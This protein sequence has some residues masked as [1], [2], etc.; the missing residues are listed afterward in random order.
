MFS[1]LIINLDF[2]YSVEPPRLSLLTFNIA[3]I[4]ILSKNENEY[5]NFPTKICNVD[6]AGKLQYLWPLFWFKTAPSVA[7]HFGTFCSGCVFAYD[8]DYTRA[9]S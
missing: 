9:S 7:I 3:T 2:V 8:A 5:Q 6:S 1:F 4:H